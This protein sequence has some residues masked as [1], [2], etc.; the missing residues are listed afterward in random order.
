MSRCAIVIMALSCFIGWVHN[1]EVGILD[2]WYIG[3]D[4]TQR[5][6]NGFDNLL[7]TVSFKADLKLRVLRERKSALGKL[8]TQGGLIIGIQEDIALRTGLL[9]KFGGRAVRHD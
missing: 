5:C 4:Q 1:S 2:G 8:L 9:P 3:L 6:I 7:N